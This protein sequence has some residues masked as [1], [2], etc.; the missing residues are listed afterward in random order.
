MNR[1]RLVSRRR[2]AQMRSFPSRVP[3]RRS[4]RLHATMRGRR[5]ICALIAL[6]LVQFPWAAGARAQVE[7]AVI[8]A[9]GAA[10]PAGGNYLFF[11]TIAVNAR[12]QVAFDAFLSGPSTSGVFVSDGMRSSAIAL[13]GKPRPGGEELSA[14]SSPRPSPPGVTSSLMRI[15]ASSRRRKAHCSAFA[16]RRPRSERRQPDSERHPCC[17]LPR[18]DRLWGVRD[19]GRPYPGHL[20]HRWYPDGSDRRRQYPPA[21]RRN[22]S[23][24]SGHR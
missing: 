23:S 5:A 7:H 4:L 14:S 12:G 9:T 21:H 8:A 10:A 13:G 18:G 20:P 1:R 17:E 6:T 3:S 22:L 11:N 2:I 16:E 19:G 15:P 24:F